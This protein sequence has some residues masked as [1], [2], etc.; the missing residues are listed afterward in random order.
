[1]ICVLSVMQ[2]CKKMLVGNGKKRSESP[3]GEGAFTNDEIGGFLR[4]SYSGAGYV[5]RSVKRKG[6]KDKKGQ[7]KVYS[8]N[9][10]IKM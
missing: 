10:Q 9:S 1:M 5:L 4:V 7:R 2:A 6:R 3:L 8:D